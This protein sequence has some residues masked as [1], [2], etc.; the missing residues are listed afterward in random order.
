MFIGMLGVAIWMAAGGDTRRFTA[1][2]HRT[3]QPT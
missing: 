2:N 3:G 1:I